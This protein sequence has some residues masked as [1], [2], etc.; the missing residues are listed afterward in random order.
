MKGVRGWDTVAGRETKSV[1]YLC[2]MLKYLCLLNQL[3][4]LGC[5]CVL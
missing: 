3:F 5:T 4:C 2:C 1:L